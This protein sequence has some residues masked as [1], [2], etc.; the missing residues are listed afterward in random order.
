LKTVNPEAYFARVF[1]RVRGRGMSEETDSLVD[2][3]PESLTVLFLDLKDST[4]YALN[5]P[6]GVVMMTLN[7][8]MAEMVSVLRAFDGR[9]SNFRGDGFLALFRG[10]DD[11]FRAVSAGLALCRKIEEFNEPRVILG[12]KKFEARIG[13]STGAAVLGNVGT[14]DMMAYTAIGTTV[15]LGA[16]LEGVAFPGIPCISPNTYRDVHKKFVYHSKSP[17]KIKPKGLEELGKMEVWDVV[18]PSDRK[19]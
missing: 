8:M 3:V 15:N 14:Y 17:R 7:R 6:P 11:A 2:G 4:A 10:N 16:R 9:M 12:M 18:G 19:P 1:R 13:I 5:T